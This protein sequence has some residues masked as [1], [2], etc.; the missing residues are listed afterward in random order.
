MQTLWDKLKQHWTAN[1]AE[2]NQPATSEAIAQFENQ[3][4]LFIPSDFKAYLSNVNGM[5]DKSESDDDFISFWALDDLKSLAEDEWYNGW[6]VMGDANEY[7]VFADHSIR[8]YDFAVRFSK[9]ATKSTPVYFVSGPPRQIADSFA[10]W[11]ERYIAGDN[12][13][14][15]PNF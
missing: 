11:I 8:V 4:Q 10:E 1:K 2:L 5:K 7:F 12:D 9:S 14:I 15:Y 3:C 13:A 6:L